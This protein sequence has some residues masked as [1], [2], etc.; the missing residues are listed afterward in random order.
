[1]ITS[2]RAL[3]SDLYFSL[4]NLTVTEIVDL[5]LVTLVFYLLLNFFRRSRAS[6]LLRGTLILVALFFI[7]TV[8]LPLP[9]FDFLLQVALVAVLIATPVLYQAELRHGLEELGRRVG[10]FNLRSAAAEI[11]MKPLVRALENL[12]ANGVGALIVLEGDDALE[13]IRDTGVPV[14]SD[15]T[16]ELLQTIFYSG[17]PLHDGAVVIRGDKV[18]A[19]GCVLPV[20]NRQLYARQRRLGTRHRAAV[21]LTETS[22]ALVLVVSEETGQ[23]SAARYGRLDT[24]L[25]RTELREQIHSFYNPPDVET[26]EFSLRS[27]FAEISEW[28]GSSTTMPE[29]HKLVS[30]LGLFL[31]SLLL[32]LTMWAF[33]IQRTNPVQEERIE[34]IPLEIVGRPNGTQLL[35]PLPDEVTAI[36]KTHDELLPSLTA[37]SFQAAASL[38]GLTPGLHRVDVDVQASVSPVQV[39]RV[40]P[41]VLDVR[42]VEV[43]TQ[44]IE[45]E[46]VTED[47][48][49]LPPA[50][51]LLPETVLT[52]T[53]V[54]IA[55]PR[56]RVEEVVS[57]IAELSVAEAT[58]TIRRIVEVVPVD[59]DGEPVPGV[60]V[61]PERVEVVLEIGPRENARE[62]AVRVV[63]VGQLPP[64]YRLRELVVEPSQV[65]LLGPEEALEGLGAFIPTTP[66]ELSRV[67]GDLQVQEALQIPPGVDAVGALG[68]TVRSVLITLDVETELGNHVLR[69]EV[70]I[71]GSPGL[72]LALQPSS[73][74]V[75]VSGPVPLLN[76][77]EASPDL[78]QVVVE[79]ADMTGL[80]PGETITLTP[81]VVAPP[82]VATQ[83][84]PRSIQI[85]ALEQP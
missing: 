12:S 69:R 47:E 2:F 32:A 4:V 51:E 27:L 63:T 23:I 42:L 70:Q 55:G 73:V 79:A 44:T 49:F 56:P 5:A 66:I 17:T 40:I 29:S 54:S 31:T 72:Q 84:L 50:F 22:D 53:Q 33:V 82:G 19:A 8:F 52:P 61:L 24:D 9:T 59:E 74:D 28:I 58:R 14:H 85:T 43:V 6:V 68:E 7:F 38:A 10:T 65:T 77:I 3:F 16:S 80:E 81:S 30:D 57:V 20:S 25:E 64:G 35:E 13:D 46:L 45:V 11:T 21:G 71:V 15:V 41:P 1:M 26:E 67:T 48:E 83:I 62:A 60:R 37:S 75:L 76:E 18:L 39:V 78:L 34:D 36:V